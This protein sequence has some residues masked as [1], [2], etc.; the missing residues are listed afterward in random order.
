MAKDD[1][2]VDLPEVKKSKLGLILAVVGGLVVLVAGV[3]GGVML[4][5]KLMGASGTAQAAT[6]PAQSEPKEPAKI[7]SAK[8][9]PLIVDMRGKRGDLHHLKVGLAAELADGVAEEDFKLVQPRGRE[10]AISYL[11]TLT[12]EDVSD[13]QKYSTIRQEL[14][15]TVTEA[16]G[17]ERVVR[18]LLVDFVAQ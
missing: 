14:S 7:V 9:D 4:G 18:I 17:K 6:A 2:K 13:P 8:F 16:V 1:E 10:A 5:P 3:A 15:Q 11:R 12:L